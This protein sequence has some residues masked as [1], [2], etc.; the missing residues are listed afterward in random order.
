MLKKFATDLTRGLRSMVRGLDADWRF[1]ERRQTIRFSCRHKVELFQMEGEKEKKSVA[2]VIDYSLGGVRL[3]N[4]G[5]IKRG[6][7]V[8]LRFPHPLPGFPVRSVECEVLWKRKNTKTLEMLAGLKF[9]ETKDRMAKS[10]VAYFFRER[11]ATLS[12]LKEDRAFYRAPCKLD[13]VCRSENDRAVGEMRDLGLGGAL[14]KVNR[15][16]EPGDKWLL[17][18][19]GVSN[20]PGMHFESTVLSCQMGEAGLYEQRVRFEGASEET[21]KLLQKYL[22]ALSKDFWTD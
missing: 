7:K 2:Y 11:G 5:T 14:I 20:F 1:T 21:K 12:D 13:V 15:P 3:S 19:S 8:K 6:E 18:V 16:A 22:T 17:D 4:P 10:W 9:L